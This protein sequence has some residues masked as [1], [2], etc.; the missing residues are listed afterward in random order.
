[1]LTIE[2]T[3]VDQARCYFSHTWN[4]IVEV[5]S[6]LSDAQWRFKPAPDRWS[7]A[8]IVEHVATVHSVVVG[9]VSQRLAEAPAPPRERDYRRAERAAKLKIALSPEEGGSFSLFM[10][11]IITLYAGELVWRERDARVDQLIDA[12]PIPTWLPFV[13]KLGALILTQALLLL[14]VMVTDSGLLVPLAS[15]DQPVKT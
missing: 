3:E 7:I 6:G 2:S 13:S 9:P 15:P 8:E 1:M 4:Q 14:V 10:L 12:L 5:T 11:I